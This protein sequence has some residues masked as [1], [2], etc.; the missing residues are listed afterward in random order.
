LSDNP[1]QKKILNWKFVL[2]RRTYQLLAWRIVHIDCIEF[3]LNSH[4]FKCHYVDCLQYFAHGSQ[5]HAKLYLFICTL[6]AT[7]FTA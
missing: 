5:D 1:K 3:A 4:Q 2:H 7:K 6:I